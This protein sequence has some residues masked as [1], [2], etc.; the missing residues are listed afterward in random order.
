MDLMFL[1]MNMI[2][3]IQ[4]SIT[5]N[6]LVLTSLPALVVLTQPSKMLVRISKSLVMLVILKN[7]D[8]KFLVHK[9][10]G[11]PILKKAKTYVVLF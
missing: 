2:Q 9:E 6:G 10:N 1:K 4:N 3:P 5:L 8:S 11:L 7:S